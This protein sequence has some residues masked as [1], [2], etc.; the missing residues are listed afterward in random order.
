LGRAYRNDENLVFT[1]ADGSP[2]DPG[3][4]TKEFKR[5]VRQAGLRDVPLHM[6]RHGA[7]SLQIEAGVDIAVVSKRMRHSKIGLT[8]DTYGHLIGTVGKTAAE[9]AAALVPRHQVG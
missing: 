8:S 4:V 6:L 7:A 1:R 3:Q 9:A 2:L 5:L